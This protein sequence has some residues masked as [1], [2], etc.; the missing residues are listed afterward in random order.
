VLG[1]HD[2]GKQDDVRL[3]LVYVFDAKGQLR[4]AHAGLFSLSVL[5]RMVVPLLSP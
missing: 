3:P 4:A 1:K 5:E 2:L